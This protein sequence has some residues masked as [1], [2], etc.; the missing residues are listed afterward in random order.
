MGT[1]SS[2]LDACC[3]SDFTALIVDF[4]G[5]RSGDDGAGGAKPTVYYFGKDYTHNTDGWAHS[6]PVVELGNI[7]RGTL[8]LEFKTSQCRILFLRNITAPQGKIF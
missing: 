6:F 5:V 7:F 1:Q 3:G 2:V 8:F 4:G